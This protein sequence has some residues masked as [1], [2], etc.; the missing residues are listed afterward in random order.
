MRKLALFDL[1][2]TITEKDTL[3]EFIVYT[4]G[5]FKYFL[6]LLILSPI[7]ILYK[8]KIIPNW[9]AKEIM[10]NWFFRNWTRE[11]LM[12]A[13]RNFSLYKLPELILDSALQRIKKHKKENDE[14]VIVSASCDVWLKDWCDLQNLQYITTE[15][16]FKN[17]R[18]TG[19][20]CTLNCHG[21]E[22]ANRIKKSLV[23]K[24]YNFIYAYGNE[25][26]DL[27]MLDLAHEKYYCHF[28]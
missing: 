11:R 27:P 8:L 12:Q 26:S 3:V 24:N 7:L 4:H 25:K 18:F 13:G 28:K 15:L 1:D 5:I 2:G 23:L 22:K 19:K 20:F 10:L 14:V 17:D 6:G 16:E 9:R 21:Q